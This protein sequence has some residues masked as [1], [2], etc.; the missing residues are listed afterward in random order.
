MWLKKKFFALLN[1]GVT[2]DISTQEVIRKKLTNHLVITGILLSTLNTILNTFSRQWPDVTAGVIII[3]VLIFIFF[4]IRKGFNKTA[5]ISLF[6]FA[7]VMFTILKVLYGVQLKM[8]PL[9]IVFLLSSIITFDSNKMKLFSLIFVTLAY[10]IGTFADSDLAIYA[11]KISNFANVNYFIF[12]A[13]L[14]YWIVKT[15]LKI[16]NQQSAL[17]KKQS[18]S[19]N[20]LIF[21][22]AHDLKTPVSNVINLSQLL[23]RKIDVINAEP[24]IKEYFSLI[25]QN[26]KEIDLRINDLQ[27][28]VV[29][30]NQDLKKT[31]PQIFI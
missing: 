15:L 29:G 14:I 1:T 8:E 2:D 20:K 5:R 28:Q 25:D 11:D 7:I 19:L 10:S 9:Y 24:E 13:F 26:A 27:K 4:L 23:G 21:S 3:S 18:E 16:H 17:L 12:S 22:T 30:P 31:A 6:V